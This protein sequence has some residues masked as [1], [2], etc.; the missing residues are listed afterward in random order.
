VLI[1]VARGP[2]FKLEERPAEISQLSQL[3]T[4]CISIAA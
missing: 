3:I 2:R 1:Y 4:H